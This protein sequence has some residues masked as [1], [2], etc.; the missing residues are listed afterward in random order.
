VFGTLLG[1]FRIV[2]GRPVWVGIRRKLKLRGR[3]R[4][5]ARKQTSLEKGREGR[6]KNRRCDAQAWRFWGED[7]KA[8]K[9]EKGTKK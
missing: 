8:S 2:R 5:I 6:E 7:L 4:G 9:I 1:G 3:I